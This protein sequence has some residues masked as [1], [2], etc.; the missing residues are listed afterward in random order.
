MS[1][2]APAPNGMVMLVPADAAGGPA[3]AMQQGG[4]GNRIDQTGT[5]RI[6]NVAPGRYQVQ[7][8]ARRPA[9]SSWRAWISSVGTDDV[10]GLTLVTAPGAVVTGSVVSDT[11]EP[12]DFRAQQLQIGARPASPDAQ[13]APAGGAVARRRRLD[14]SRCATSST[15]RL[16]ARQ[17]PQGWAMK[18]VFLNGQDITDT[19][20]EFPP[21]QTVSG[22]QIVLTKK[23]T[24]LSG[25][26]PTHAATR[27][28]TRP[29][30]CFPATRSSGP[31]S[32]AS[33]RRRGPIRTA[34][35]ASPGCPAPED[36]LVVAVQGL[37]D[38]QAGD[39]EFLATIKD[40]ATKLELGEGESKA[41][42]VKLSARS[43]ED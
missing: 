7:A 3:M 4:A 17:P 6:T 1:D 30:W 25:R 42:D 40:L 19:P 43:D 5:F 39:P 10:D 2:G 11:G 22:M 27:C 41:V 23:I 26:S 32:R 15:R 38:G 33:S 9:S 20:T 34:S 16:F 12:F 36:Y 29:S 31:S 24:S 21:G 18:S 37:E 13:A 35:I 28:S 14:P 8:R